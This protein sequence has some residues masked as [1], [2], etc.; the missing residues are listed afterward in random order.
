MN[1]KKL[2][3]SRK[4]VQ[5]PFHDNT[6]IKKVWGEAWGITSDIGQLRKVLMHRPGKEVLKLHQNQKEIEAGPLL[7]KY[8]KG[9]QP[10]DLENKS[11]PNLQGEE[12]T[13]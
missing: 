7:G 5:E 6:L 3:F 2:N 4:L 10:E 11:K 12:Y 9:T 8:I 1:N 13:A